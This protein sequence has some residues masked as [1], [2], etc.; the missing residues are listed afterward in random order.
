MIKIEILSESATETSAAF[1]YPVPVGQQ[2]PAAEDQLREPSGVALSLEETQD[3]KDGKIYEYIWTSS[4]GGLDVPQRRSKLVNEWATNQADA[5][6][7]YKS[8]FGGAGDYYDDT[9]HD[10]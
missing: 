2:L 8:R 1:Y 3:L 4:T 10:A 6:R 9:W 7:E 5:I